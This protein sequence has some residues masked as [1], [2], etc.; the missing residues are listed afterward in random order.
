MIYQVVSPLG[1]VLFETISRSSAELF[2]RKSGIDPDAFI[3]LVRPYS[4]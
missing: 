4:V 3:W 2:C 1:V